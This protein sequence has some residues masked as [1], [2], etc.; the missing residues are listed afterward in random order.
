[1]ANFRFLNIKH[2]LEPF[3]L[4]GVEFHIDSYCCYWARQCKVGNFNFIS[5]FSNRY[6]GLLCLEYFSQVICCDPEHTKYLK[7][8]I[9]TCVTLI[10]FVNSYEVVLAC[11]S[12]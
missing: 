4:K 7:T 11:S 12:H 2:L 3:K 9:T 10:T 6:L 8:S 1:M 5:Y